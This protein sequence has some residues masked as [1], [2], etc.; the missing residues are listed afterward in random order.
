MANW[1]AMFG[2]PCLTSVP[3]AQRPAVVASA[4]EH[5]RRHLWREGRWTADYRRLRI[6]AMNSDSSVGHPTSNSTPSSR[7][8]DP[9]GTHA[10][11]MKSGFASRWL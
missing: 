10:Y 8:N 3:E 4:I 1:L 5:M 2:Q 6:V 7:L 11:F 9:S